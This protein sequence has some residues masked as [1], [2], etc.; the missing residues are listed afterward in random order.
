MARFALPILQTKYDGFVK[1]F[2][3]REQPH[4]RKEVCQIA[5]LQD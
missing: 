2:A 3:G 5:L 1:S 4:I